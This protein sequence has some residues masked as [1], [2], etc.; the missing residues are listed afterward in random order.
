MNTATNSPIV[1]VALVADP[2][3]TDSEP[4]YRRNFRRGRTHLQSL[5]ATF[6]QDPSLD[7]IINLGDF[8]NGDTPDELPVMAEIFRQSRIPVYHT[9]GNHDLNLN[10]LEQLSEHLGQKAFFYDFSI[11]PFR[12]ISVNSC[13]ESLFAPKD[14][15]EYIRI[16]HYLENHPELRTWNGRLSAQ[17]MDWLRNRL[18]DARDCGQKAIIFTHIPIL[19]QTSQAGVTLY[20][21][22]DMLALLDQFPEV[23]AW[24]AGHDH[25]GST[26]VRNGVLHKSVMGLC[27]TELPTAVIASLYPGRM[28][29]EAIGNETSAV[30]TF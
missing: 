18:A 7:F 30:H 13:D 5:I 20:D 28:E 23:I 29:L 2:Q 3:Y 21:Y 11:G 27:E 16:Q 1:R 9:P 22:Q 17:H 12:F 10:T 25:D 15:P 4:K 24:I 19:S 14:S 6:N 8:V 26:I